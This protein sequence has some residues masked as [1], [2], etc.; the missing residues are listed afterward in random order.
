MAS[1]GFAGS[2]ASER[3]TA[4][5][6]SF[7]TAPRFP[8]AREGTPGP[9][10]HSL[11]SAIGKQSYGHR[12]SCPAFSFGTNESTLNLGSG[13]PLGSDTPESALG[14][15]RRSQHPTAGAPTFG[16]RPRPATSST[17]GPGAY[18]VRRFGHHAAPAGASGFGAAPRFARTTSPTVGPGAYDVADPVARRLLSQSSLSS[19]RQQP[20]FSFG[21]PSTDARFPLGLDD[22]HQARWRSLPLEAP[23]MAGRLSP[24]PGELP[25]GALG[26]APAYSLSPKRRAPHRDGPGPAD[27]SPRSL[28][29]DGRSKLGGAMAP[30]RSLLATPRRAYRPAPSLRGM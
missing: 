22:Y 21:G 26:A 6:S 18:N 7:G 29:W 25:P 23:K 9:G 20:A 13:A 1:S 2:F 17:P 4:P 3:S 14:V 30:P 24:G 15:Q 11:A 10:A 19:L 5:T 8:A 16:G 12:R 27:Y 28:Y